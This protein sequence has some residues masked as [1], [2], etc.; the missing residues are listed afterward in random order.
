MCGQASG[1][2]ASAGRLPGDPAVGRRQQEPGRDRST[3]LSGQASEPLPEPAP[4]EEYLPPV[5][6]PIGSL[7]D[8]PRH[9][10]GVEVPGA[11]ARPAVA[12]F[13]EALTVAVEGLARSGAGPERGEVPGDDL[14]LPMSE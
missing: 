10:F 9:R 6:H 8:D 14:R 2:P 11:E 1:G 12:G 5:P 13:E 4:L 3:I 7:E